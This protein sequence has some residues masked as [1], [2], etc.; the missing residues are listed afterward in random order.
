MSGPEFPI[1][2]MFAPVSTPA[3]MI[4]DLSWLMLAICAAIFVV[5]A[6]LLI[7]VIVRFRP[8]RGR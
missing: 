7:H 6:Y 1:P 3:F 4:R 2:S 8:A 5:V